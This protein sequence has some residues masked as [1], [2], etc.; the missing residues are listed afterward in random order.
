MGEIT[1]NEIALC[2]DR[3][4]HKLQVEVVCEEDA[5]EAVEVV[6]VV[7]VEARVARINHHLHQESPMPI[8]SAPTHH[9]V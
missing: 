2:L 8:S 3:R 1:S 4:N 6:E 5:T 7:E 9:V